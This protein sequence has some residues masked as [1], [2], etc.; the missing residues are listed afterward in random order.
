METNE[1]IRRRIFSF[2]EDREPKKPAPIES[3][4]RFYR[5]M[6][7]AAAPPQAHP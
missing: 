1:K 2:A 6:S 5:R 7:R 3:K 4:I